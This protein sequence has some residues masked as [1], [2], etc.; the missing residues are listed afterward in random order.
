MDKRIEQPIP[1]ELQAE[2]FEAAR[3]AA[4]TGLSRSVVYRL[5]KARTLSAGATMGEN[6]ERYRTWRL[7]DDVDVALRDARGVVYQ[8]RRERELA[9]LAVIER[10]HIRA[11]V[12]ERIVSKMIARLAKRFAEIPELAL[13]LGLEDATLRGV[14]DGAAMLRNRLARVREGEIDHEI[15]DDAQ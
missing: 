13:G 8:G 2:P 6:V 9:R 4:L 10:A 7:A 3:F 14:A 5:V 15:E 12:A 11:D 1:P